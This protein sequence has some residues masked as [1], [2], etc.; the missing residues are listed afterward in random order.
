MI[1]R[2]PRS[3]LFPYTTLFR[4]LE[5]RQVVHSLEF[6]EQLG[7]RLAQQVDQQVQPPAVGHADDDLLDPRGTAPLDEIIQQRYEG[8]PALEREALL[9]HI[10]GVQ[11]ALEPFGGGELPQDVAPLLGAEAVLQAPR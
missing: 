5:V 11:V 6:G 7:R 1:R 9:T 10:L 4:S 3:T 8:I 2:P